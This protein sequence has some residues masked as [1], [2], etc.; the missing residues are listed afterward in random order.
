MTAPVIEFSEKQARFIEAVVSGKFRYLAYGGGIRG[1]KS[2]AGIGALIVLC[3]VFP[4]SRWAVVRKDLPT[5]RRNTLPTFE[6]LRPQGFMGDVNRSTWEVHCTNGS[7]L[8]FFPEAIK[9][10]PDLNRWRGLEVNGFL[11]EEANEIKQASFFKAIER[12]GSWIVR[13]G[14]QPPPLILAT[15]NPNDEWP[16]RV[17]YEPHMSGSL[18]AP[19]HYL[20]A[21]IFDNPHVPPE[22]LESL[23]ALPEPE[24]NRF[25]L[26]RWDTHTLPNQLIHAEW[27]WKAR[28]IE[29]DLT[30]PFRIGLDVARYGDDSTVMS[31]MRGGQAMIEQREF[32]DLPTDE[33]G[34]QAIAYANFPEHP[35]TADE[36]R[37]DGVGMGSGTVDHMRRMGWDVRDVQ[38]GGGM[39]ER[40]NSVFTFNNLRSQMWWEFREKL[41]NGLFSFPAEMDERLVSDLTS[42]RYEISDKEISVWSKKLLKKELGR[43][44]DHGDSLI[45]GAFDFPVR[46]RP[47]VSPMGADM[48]SPYSD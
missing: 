48:A 9:E 25:V 3:R 29:P 27:V 28:D 42:L 20:P 13:D 34:D 46:M 5:I 45:Y 35:V 11:L 39:I 18:Q 15:F 26:G 17:W 7:S 23:K 43:S 22:Y 44:T 1:G 32:K 30:L 36:I 4:G 19:Y 31:L 21:T 47:I 40:P 10:D 37:V 6:K 41:R 2:F 8:L 24:Y 33:V 16:R 14:R 38:S 12:A